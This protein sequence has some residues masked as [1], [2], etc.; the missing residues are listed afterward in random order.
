[1]LALASLPVLA[2]GSEAVRSVTEPY[3]AAPHGVA[4]F[5]LGTSIMLAALLGGSLWRRIRVAAWTGRLPGR[6]GEL[7]TETRP[8]HEPPRGFKAARLVAHPASGE[9]SFLGVT[10]GGRY[11]VETD[12]SCEVLAGTL[13]PSRRWGRRQLPELHDAPDL[14]CTCGFYAFHD[15]DSALELLSVRPPISRVLGL[16]LLEVDLSGTVIEFDRGYRASRQQVLGVQV[17]RW[18]VPCAARGQR[19]RAQRMGGLSAEDFEEALRA[20][21]PRYPPLYRL[22]LSLHQTALL[23]RLGGRTALRAV[24]DRHTPTQLVTEDPDL[25]PPPALELA[26][27]AAR[28]GTEVCWLDDDNFDVEAFVD[29]MAWLPAGAPRPA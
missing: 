5:A 1:V 23:E 25:A 29:A 15:R 26:D 21:L 28:L 11:G 10:L 4:A 20:E 9:A 19:H 27:L 3:L 22:A 8:S 14:D 16:I 7:P 12:A 6:I 18:C 2:S 24:C 17:P 13:P